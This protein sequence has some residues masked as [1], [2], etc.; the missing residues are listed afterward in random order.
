MPFPNQNNQQR[1]THVNTRGLQMFNLNGFDPSTMIVSMWNQLVSIRIHPAKEKS[2]QTKTSV[3]D[4]DKSVNIVLDTKTANILGDIILDEMIPALKENSEFTKGIPVGSNSAIILSTGVRRSGGRPIPYIAIA[5]NIKPGSLLPDDM[6][7]Y[8]FNTTNILNKYD[9]T[10]GNNE[11]DIKTCTVQIHSELRLFGDL[12][13]YMAVALIGAEYHAGR[14][15]NKRY[16]D[17][18][19]QLYKGIAAKYGLDFY[20]GSGRAEYASRSG[21]VFNTSSNNDF[22][23]T[24]DTKP[25]MVDTIE[26]LDL[27]AFAS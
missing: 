19:F 22:K 24:M 7:S 14:N 13:K 20:S 12:M 16:D 23:S 1:D 6:L 11:F 2:Q 8:T 21:S 4:Y 3:Y 5:R 17:N 18:V 27:D 10:P 26:E 25:E 15:I 9:G